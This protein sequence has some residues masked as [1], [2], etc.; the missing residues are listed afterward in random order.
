[1]IDRDE[2]LTLEQVASETGVSRSTVHAWRR[3]GVDGVLLPFLVIGKRAVRVRRSDL[4]AFLDG[5]PRNEF[6]P[7]PANREGGRR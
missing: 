4:S 5:V 2:F 7:C 3:D 6:R 1:M